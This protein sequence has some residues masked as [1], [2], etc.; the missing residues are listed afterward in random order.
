MYKKSLYKTLNSICTRTIFFYNKWN[1]VQVFSIDA[2]LY[3][4]CPTAI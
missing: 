2:Q 3:Q 4:Q 1:T